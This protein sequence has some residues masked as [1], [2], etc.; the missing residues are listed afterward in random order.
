MQDATVDKSDLV[1][2]GQDITDLKVV[3][4]SEV[5]EESHGVVRGVNFVVFHGRKASHRMERSKCPGNSTV[6]RIDDGSGPSV[7]V[8]TV[9]VEKR[10]LQSDQ[11]PKYIGFMIL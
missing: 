9:A 1:S 4:V 6:S 7:I 8:V 2:R 3:T 5:T 10:P 11:P